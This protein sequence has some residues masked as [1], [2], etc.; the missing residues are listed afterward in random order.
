MDSSDGSGR[1]ANVFEN[2]RR[3]T[4]QE[5]ESLL[6]RHVV[7]VLCAVIS[8]HYANNGAGSTGTAADRIGPVWTPLLANIWRVSC[9]LH[10]SEIGRYLRCAY[11]RVPQP[12]RSPKELG[13]HFESFVAAVTDPEGRAR[14]SR[15][16]DTLGVHSTCHSYAVEVYRKTRDLRL[17]QRLLGHSSPVTTMVYANLLDDHVRARVEKVWAA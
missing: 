6:L 10:A 8:E 17:T 11:S 13:R 5:F 4:Y 14:P 1:T 12:R 15:P 7:S 2:R 16:A 3:A 9:S